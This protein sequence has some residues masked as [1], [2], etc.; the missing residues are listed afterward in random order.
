MMTGLIIILLMVFVLP[1][2][3]KAVEE[4]L[5]AFL[6]IMGISAC[7]ISGL[8]TKEL[9]IEAL[10]EPIMIAL[11]VLIAGALFYVL[12]KQFALFMNWVYKKV[13][14]SVV[15]FFTVAL[16]GLLSS[17]IT[18]IVAS[19][20]LVEIIALLPVA[21]KQ[22]IVICI[23]A[24]FSIGLG[25]VL[26]PLGEPLATIAVS[27]MNEDFLY[28]FNLLGKFI[29]PSV[30]LMAALGAVYTS[31]I[32]RHGAALA[33]NVENEVAAT[34]DEHGEYV[35]PPMEE[36][37]I[38]DLIKQEPEAVATEAL[39]EQINDTDINDL[40]E[41]LER[42]AQTQAAEKI[43]D[44]IEE[45]AIQTN[46]VDTVDK[47]EAAPL[48]DYSG[49]EAEME[50]EG[51]KGIFMRAAKVYLF[52]M[53]LVFLGEGF[54][55][56]IDKYVLTLD[57]HYLYWINMISAVLDNATL[58]AAELSPQM[59]QIQVEMILMGLLVSGGMLIPGNIPN[60]IS[61][62]KLKITS[63]EWAIIGVPMGLILMTV[64][65]FVLL[66]L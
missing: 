40:V 50:D 32:M 52:V 8:M 21:R 28:L 49:E 51:W 56:L 27:K 43:I 20:I 10:E 4:N 59:T 22:K 12:K 15:V 45:E 46:I 13:P 30:L 36:L 11:A 44:L 41:W 6:F 5:E 38:Y 31:H 17:V 29:I 3:I 1:F 19:I 39:L 42:D 58:T 2:S 7:L 18:A 24:C 33:G 25:A 61:A 37:T 64:M 35:L 57:Y 54:A 66:Y 48:E 47:I 34:E 14:V 23:I 16:L 53:A 60:I 26:T 9:A 65:Y 62:S 55:P 63:K